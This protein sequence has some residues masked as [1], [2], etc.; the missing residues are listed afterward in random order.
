M[1][2]YNLNW[3]YDVGVVYLKKDMV[4]SL[5]TGPLVCYLWKFN[6]YNDK[7]IDDLSLKDINL[8]VPI[9]TNLDW[10]D[11]KDNVRSDPKYLP[12]ILTFPDTYAVSNNCSFPD[13]FSKGESLKIGILMLMS[14]W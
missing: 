14:I 5:I 12:P 1:Y 13:V 4:P 10:D 11:C 2:N 3:I 9:T 8:Y 6:I 7:N